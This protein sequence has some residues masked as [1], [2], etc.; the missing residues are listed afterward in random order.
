MQLEQD[1][2]KTSEIAVMLMQ[3]LRHLP[4]NE[5]L[6][7]VKADLALEILHCVERP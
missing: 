5:E 3:K 7:G 4:K 6:Q 2:K 1:W